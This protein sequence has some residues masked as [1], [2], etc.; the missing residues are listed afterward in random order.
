M[1]CGG[2]RGIEREFFI[3]N[4]LVRIHFIIVVIRWTGLAPFPF[5]GSLTSTFLQG[6]NCT[7]AHIGTPGKGKPLPLNPTPY[8]L[9]PTPYTL[10]P[11]PYTLN[12]TPCT[13]QVQG[14]Q[15]WR[16]GDRLRG[17]PVRDTN[18]HEP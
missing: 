7:F 12:P 15:D 4:L 8:T 13:R 11:T 17:F 10:H 14:A 6:D 3:D 16:G 9:H 18:V 1:E 5:P 2:G